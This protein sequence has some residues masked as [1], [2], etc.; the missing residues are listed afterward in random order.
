[1]PRSAV[2]DLSP[3]AC[4]RQGL[5]AAVPP[6][7][8]RIPRIPIPEALRG[9]AFTIAQARAAGLG[10]GRLGGP[11]LSRPTH[12]VRSL[13]PPETFRDRVL[14]TRVALPSDVAFSHLTAARLWGLPL[15]LDLEDGSIDVMR[16][17]SASRVRRRGCVGRRGLESRATAVH[18]G[19]LLTSLED[20]WCD[21]GETLELDDLVVVGDAVAR[22]LADVS[23]LRDALLRR[24]RPRGAVALRAAL[25]LVRVGSDSPMESRCRLVFHRAGL[26]EPE[27]NAVITPQHRWLPVQGRLRLAGAP[28]PGRVPGQ[29]PLRVVPPGGRRYLATTAA[30]GRRLEV[31]GDDQARPLPPGETGRAGSQAGGIPAVRLGHDLGP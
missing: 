16:A 18:R 9:G 8:G 20:T 23:P 3:P 24:V 19:V 11:D 5:P 17:T 12:G 27:L 25:G 2:R 15:P 31:R 22:R 10:P 26:P 14:A 1:M 13:E 28:R 4:G 7:P 21:V 29:Q 30:R 6:H